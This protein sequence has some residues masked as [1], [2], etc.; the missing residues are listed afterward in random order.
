MKY[1]HEADAALNNKRV[2]TLKYSFEVPK[3]YKTPSQITIYWKGVLPPP[4]TNNS[5]ITKDELEYLSTLTRLRTP[6]EE[7]LVRMVDDDPLNVYLDIARKHKLKVPKQRIKRA[8]NICLPVIRNIKWYHNRPRPEQLGDLLG[9]NINV[10]TTDTHQTPAYPSG[11]TAYAGLVAAIFSEEYPDYSSDFYRLVST[12][13]LAR[14]LQ[15]V[16]YPT[17]NDAG[18]VIAGALWED[19][20][21]KI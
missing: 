19:I 14:C 5:D 17:D 13:G 2:E 18:M 6:Q 11:H 21:F 12:V 15:G 7:E 20:R 4:P 10:M 9:Y 8:W 16:H 1:I 3:K